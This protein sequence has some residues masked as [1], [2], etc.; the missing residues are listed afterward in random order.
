[1]QGLYEIAYKEGFTRGV[2][3]SA[4][5]IFAARNMEVP[6]EVEAQILSCTDF[7]QLESHLIGSATVNQVEEL[8][9]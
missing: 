7:V 4:L 8:F 1:M 9:D 5:E 6:D 3:E 2:A